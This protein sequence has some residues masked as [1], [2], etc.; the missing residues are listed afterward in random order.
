MYA[1]MYVCLR[2]CQ[3]GQCCKRLGY[4]CGTAGRYL[5]PT[6]TVGTRFGPTRCH[7]CGRINLS[8]GPLPGK[9]VASLRIPTVLIFLSL[10]NLRLLLHSSSCQAFFT[11]S[12]RRQCGEHPRPH[13]LLRE[14]S[15]LIIFTLP[16]QSKPP[17]M[18]FWRKNG[19]LLY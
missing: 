14:N 8:I 17:A 10:M 12:P 18:L 5:C 7:V 1:C 16:P 19:T 6:R 4:S 3:H 11:S 2:V 13:K 9:Y 15:T